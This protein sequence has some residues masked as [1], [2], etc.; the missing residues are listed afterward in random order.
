ML[1]SADIRYRTAPFVFESWMDHNG[2]ARVMVDGLDVLSNEIHGCPGKLLDEASFFPSN[3]ASVVVVVMTNKMTRPLRA[4][5]RWF[6]VPRLQLR[7]I[8]TIYLVLDH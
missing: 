8:N 6:M 7:S 1:P 2:V 4:H 5:T 3:T